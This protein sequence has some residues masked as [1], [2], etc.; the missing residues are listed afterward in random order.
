[1]HARNH[2]CMRACTHACLLSGLLEKPQWSMCS[3]RQR[4]RE[5]GGRRFLPA[6]SYLTSS[7][8]MP[9][10][11][12]WNRATHPKIKPPHISSV[13]FSIS[14]SSTTDSA[15]ILLLLFSSIPFERP[16]ELSWCCFEQY[17]SPAAHAPRIQAD[18]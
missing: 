18:K 6:G 2:T 3:R 7:T 1:M 12:T 13:Y 9:A 14:T 8:I 17:Q 4:G 11:R 10:K 16:P 15:E 5:G